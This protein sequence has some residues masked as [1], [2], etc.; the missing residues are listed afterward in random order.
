MSVLLL[1]VV[2]DQFWFKHHEKVYHL[3][4]C[5]PTKQPDVAFHQFAVW[6]SK[7]EVVR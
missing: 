2:F 5:M 7:Q 1:A 6:R 3:T 4:R